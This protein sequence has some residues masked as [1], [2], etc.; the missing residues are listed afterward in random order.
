MSEDELEKL[1]ELT[2]EQ[3]E[4][5]TATL[6]W[7][8]AKPKIDIY[9]YDAILADAKLRNPKYIS[10]EERIKLDNKTALDFWRQQ[11]V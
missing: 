11:N 5:L 8:E 7:Q 3:E 1:M 4:Q 2:P 9:D 10:L 6:A